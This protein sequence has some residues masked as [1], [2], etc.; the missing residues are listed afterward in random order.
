V[1]VCLLSFGV[2]ADFLMLLDFE[3]SATSDIGD[4]GT[5][6]ATDPSFGDSSCPIYAN[7]KRQG[8]DMGTPFADWVSGAGS[9]SASSRPN[10][11]CERHG[12]KT[13]GVTSLYRRAPS[14]PQMARS[15]WNNSPIEVSVVTI[16][17]QDTIGMFLR[18]QF[19]ELPGAPSQLI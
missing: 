7:E 17:F 14:D 11:G 10:T 16:Y 9:G 4:S 15:K 8:I 13:Q 5:P 18:Y 2:K 1:F 12:I 3:G 19:Q 6:V